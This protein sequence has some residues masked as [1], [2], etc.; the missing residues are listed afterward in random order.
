MTFPFA[1]S[2]REGNRAF[3]SAALLAWINDVNKWPL[4]SIYR[5]RL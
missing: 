1:E 4:T 3:R 5:I 2:M